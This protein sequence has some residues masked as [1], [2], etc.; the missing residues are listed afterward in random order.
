MKA[1]RCKK[2][3]EV[4]IFIDKMHETYADQEEHVPDEVNFFAGA[5]CTLYFE[6]KN[7]VF[8]K[9]QYSLVEGDNWIKPNGT[10][11]VA[12]SIDTPAVPTKGGPI[13]VVP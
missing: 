3:K 4:F 9:D 12:Y 5:P 2:D 6:P 1:A 8:A 10:G 11:S 13:I 7:K